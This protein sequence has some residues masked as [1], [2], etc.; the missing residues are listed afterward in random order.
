MIHKY[1]ELKLNASKQRLL[2]STSHNITGHGGFD[3]KNH[4]KFGKNKTKPK[5]THFSKSKKLLF[6][7]HLSVI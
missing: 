4:L 1:T 6:D 5:T 7:L 3:E 2:T